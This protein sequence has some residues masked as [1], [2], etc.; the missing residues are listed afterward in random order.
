MS[1][2]K[3]RKNA[4]AYAFSGLWHAFK[5]EAHLQLH[6]IIGAIVIIAGFYFSISKYDWL[7]VAG[8]IAF[9][10]SL[11]LI[12]SA[13]EKLCD[14]YS[15]EYNPKIKYIKDVMAAAVLVASVFA[16]ITGVFVFFPYIKQLFSN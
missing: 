12:N 2:L 8:C 14:L 1:Y 16:A 11:E 7:I 10:I 15:K 9:V 3:N 4:F 6:L 13:I 5:S